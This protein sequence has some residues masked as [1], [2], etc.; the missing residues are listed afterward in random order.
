M[1]NGVKK[2]VIRVNTIFFIFMSYSLLFFY[3]MEYN[4]LIDL[5]VL[6]SIFSLNTIPDLGDISATQH[7]L[8]HRGSS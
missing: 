1:L 5:K 3:S 2:R 7:D 6:K 4:A 8:S